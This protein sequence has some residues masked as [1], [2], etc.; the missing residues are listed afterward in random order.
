MGHKKIYEL[1]KLEEVDIRD[2]WKHEQ[3]DFSEWL[4]APENIERLND[5]L[6]LTLVEVQKEAYVGAYRCDILA[7]DEASGIKIVIENQLEDSN[8]EHLGKIITYASGLDASVVV[9]IVR[10]AREEHKSAIEWLNNNTNSNVDFFLMEVH[11]YRIGDSLPAVK[12][13]VVEMPNGFIKTGKASGAN[14]EMSKSQSERL[15]FWTAFNDCVIERGKPF[16]VRKATTDNWY[17]IAI[18]T[19][20][21]HIAITLVNKGGYIGVELYINDS[22]ELFDSLYLKKEEIEQKLNMKFE[23]KRLDNKKASGI[24]YRLQGLNFEDHSNYP[25]LMNQIIDLVVPMRNVFS[26]YV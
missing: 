18:G 8:H 11:A 6:G 25:Q 2:I 19:S 17:D 9:W 5:I 15:E 21:A 1:G 23:W 12:F 14:G 13:E 16:S 7:Q 20:K 3:Y 10:K 26:K 22:K 4:A 24:I